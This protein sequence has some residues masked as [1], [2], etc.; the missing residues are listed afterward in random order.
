MKYL[1]ILFVCMHHWVHAQD[2]DPNRRLLE[3]GIQLGEMKAPI[4]NYAKAVQSGD[5]KRVG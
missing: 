5:R 4:A 3:L 1:L 2:I